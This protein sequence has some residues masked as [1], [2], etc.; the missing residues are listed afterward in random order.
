M[1]NQFLFPGFIIAALL[2]CQNSFAANWLYTIRPGD[3][4]WDLCLEYTTEKACWYKLDKINGVKFPRRLPPGFVVSFPVG[5]LK[6]VPTPVEVSYV[7]GDVRVHLQTGIKAVVAG[8]KLPIGARIVTASG[9][10]NLIFADGSTMQLEPYSELI[11]DTLSSFDGN[12]MVDSRLRLKQGAV[13][14]RVIK[15]QPASRFQITTPTAVAAVRGTQYRVSSVVGEQTL[16]RSEVFEGLVDVEANDTQQAVA[17]GFG[18]V[19][20]RGEPLAAPRP[21]LPPASFSFSNAAQ[22][23]PAIVS[24]Q[25]LDGALSYQL[26][27]LADNDND[28]VFQRIELS[29]LSYTVN[30]LPI[31][32]YRLRLRG[33]DIDS[34]QGS[35]SQQKLCIVP[36]LAVP[37]LET[38]NMSYRGKLASVLGWQ[39]VK[40]ALQYR[41]QIAYD[42]DFK[43]IVD[44]R[45]VDEPQLS[46]SGNGPLFIRVQA[47]GNEGQATSFSNTIEWQP[48]ERYWVPLILTGLF[49]FVVL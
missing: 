4:I 15:R 14:T 38:D 43:L 2:V 11:L 16:T 47:L 41:V 35:A 49:I 44:E 22:V 23:L 27:I 19:A 25:P 36:A 28:E 48:R 21:L 30:T 12:G 24:W 29:T 20:K 45:L 32:C 42:V 1:K 18:I 7:K 8:D 39:G 9:D 26:E 37:R 34:L 46:F 31:G 6:K 17:A 40:D 33:I 3:T 13:K 10:I 5:W